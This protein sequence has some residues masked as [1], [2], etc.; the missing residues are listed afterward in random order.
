[1]SEQENTG[2]V[3]AQEVVDRMREIR[4]RRAELKKRFEE[5]DRKLRE[6]W[7]RGEA[8]LMKHIQET[9]HK[10]FKVDGATV[11]TSVNTRYKVPDKEAFKNYLLSTGDLDLAQLS[12]NKTNMKTHL[13]DGGQL[14]PG[15]DYEE[16]VSVNIRKA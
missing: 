14:P 16:I 4:D 2:G 8:W 10:S 12:V 11:F 3:T 6:Q 13:E 5:H 1:M 9:G 7:D 15:V